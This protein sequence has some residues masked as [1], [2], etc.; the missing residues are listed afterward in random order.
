MKA[1]INNILERFVD[2]VSSHAYEETPILTAYVDI[3]TT[4]PAN[5]RE[6]PAWLVDLKNEYR[7]IQE[8]VPAEQFKRRSSQVRWERAEEMVL[9]WLRDRK[10]S[11]RSMVL[12][13]DLNDSFVA[14][15]LP[16]R[17]ETRL[18]YGLPQIKHLLFALDQYKKYLVLLFGQSEVRMVEVF[19]TRTSD[20]VVV[21]TDHERLR[22]LSRKAL[23]DGQD[24]RGPEFQS[25]YIRDVA[26]SISGFFLQ[27]PDIERLVLGGNT[28]LATRVYSALHPAAQEIVVAITP[29]DA[30]LPAS[31]IAT[32]IRGLAT[33]YEQEHDTLEVADLLAL[34]RQGGAAALGREEVEKAMA[35][36]RVR[37]LVLPYPMD[38]A[39]FDAL[40]V[41][42]TVQGIAIEFVFGAAADELVALGGIGAHLYYVL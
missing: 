5:M 16:V 17:M 34:H 28:Q 2:Y 37:S 8:E 4:N 27:D 36:S 24:R 10:P 38:V 26:A 6:R 18:Y 40:I 3:D 29:M 13:T 21:E 7:R 25:R 22:R 15:D 20:E 39:D 23:E 30:D 35:Q 1:E 32:R 41:A 31:E 33:T 42:A 11:G 14:V 19:L 9:S 12:F